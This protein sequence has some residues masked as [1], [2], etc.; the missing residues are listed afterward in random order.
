MAVATG[1]AMTLSGNVALKYLKDGI[2]WA[3]DK[4]TNKVIPYTSEQLPKLMFII[5]NVHKK[6]I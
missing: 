3:Y 1:E 6:E 4:I 2:W 5:T